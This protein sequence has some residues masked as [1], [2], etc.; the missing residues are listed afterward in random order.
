MQA[1]GH[2][3]GSATSSGAQMLSP[4]AL[5]DHSSVSRI[6]GRT[7]LE[8]ASQQ[9]LHGSMGG[10]DIAR[11]LSTSLD[12]RRDGEGPDCA[13]QPGPSPQRDEQVLWSTSCVPPEV[14]SE[15]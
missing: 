15:E 11:L 4:P 1:Q 14:K 10:S 5:F 12:G 6:L 7:A 13:A 2:V 9:Q 8:Q 3:L